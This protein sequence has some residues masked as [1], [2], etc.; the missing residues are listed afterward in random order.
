M[1]SELEVKKVDLTD[2]FGSF[3]TKKS[4]QQFKDMVRRGWQ[5]QF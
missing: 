4:G 1:A 3:K 2:I 5:K